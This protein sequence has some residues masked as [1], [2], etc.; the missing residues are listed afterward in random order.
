MGEGPKR[1][2]MLLWHTHRLNEAALPAR[3]QWLRWLA[4]DGSRGVKKGLAA[5]ERGRLDRLFG[6][7]EVLCLD[8]VLGVLLRQSPRRLSVWPFGR[9]SV[10]VL[11][12]VR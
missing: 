10:N 5:L 4:P 12:T 9:H 7:V 6:V 11:K 8:H 2:M 1:F 3:K